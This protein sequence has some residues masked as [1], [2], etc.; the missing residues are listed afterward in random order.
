MTQT[1]R[2]CSQ[3]KARFHLEY[4]QVHRE[5]TA[6]RSSNLPPRWYSARF[7]L[8]HSNWCRCPKTRRTSAWSDPFAPLLPRVPF[9][10]PVY[11]SP[12][13]LLSFAARAVS[14]QLVYRSAA[15]V[16]RLRENLA[17]AL[18]KSHLRT[19]KTASI[20]IGSPIGENFS[21]CHEELRHAC[22]PTVRVH[23]LF[24]LA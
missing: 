14:P 20:N 24:H 2:C 1:T 16:S 18:K 8:T 6:T 11:L 7:S 9:P 17:F 23:V 19:P 21:A 15:C 13:D 5:P 4:F 22:L 12:S 3:E 10:S